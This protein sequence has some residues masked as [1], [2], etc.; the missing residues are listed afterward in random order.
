[1]RG[2]GIV[3]FIA[4]LLALVIFVHSRTGVDLESLYRGRRWFELRDA[5]LHAGRFPTVYRAAVT[6]AFHDFSE[7]ERLASNVVRSASEPIDMI[8]ARYIL[9]DTYA[10]EERYAAALAQLRAVNRDQDKSDIALYSAAVQFPRQLVITRRTSRVPWQ[11]DPNGHLIFPVTVNGRLAH[12]ELDTGSSYCSISRTEADRLGLKTVDM[13]G[14][15]GTDGS[16][17]GFEAALAS[18][19]KVTVGGFEFEH[20]LFE[21]RADNKELP[22]GVLGMHVILAFETITWGR[23]GVLEIGAPTGP[24]NIR[25]ANLCFDGT[26]L[27]ARALFQK[28]GIH[29]FLDSGASDIDF[30][31]RFGSDFPAVARDKSAVGRSRITGVGG[32]VEEPVVFLPEIE[33]D[34]GNASV[35]TNRAVLRSK[36]LNGWGYHAHAGSRFL[37]GATIDLGAMKFGYQ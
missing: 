28:A 37:Q 5:L 29:V 4:G 20:V 27:I 31:P 14:F 25:E 36:D 30:L 17:L 23:D 1:M 21:V 10:Q 15:R 7:A 9:A 2:V 8:R 19:D 13:P 32:T 6:F 24:V 18:A 16:G 26:H 22:P 33:L 12:Y 35:R 11:A 3:L 34:V